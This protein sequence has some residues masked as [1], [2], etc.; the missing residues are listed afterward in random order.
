LFLEQD[1]EVT[2]HLNE[3]YASSAFISL[4][5]TSLSPSSRVLST[6]A[7]SLILALSASSPSAAA[8]A[9]TAERL[10]P[11]YRA[12]LAPLDVALL[13]LFQRIEIASGRSIAPILKGWNPAAA[14]ATATLLDGSRVGALGASQRPFVRRSWARAFASTRTAY[15]EAD[16]ARTYDPRFIVSLVGALVAEDELK[17]AEWTTVLESG[18]V[19]TVVA[20]L[21]SSEKSLRLQARATLG[22]LLRKI[23]VRLLCSL[24]LSSSY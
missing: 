20:S 9:R 22:G 12:T 6:P 17:V 24:D 15:S 18:A 21:A 14:D 7:L 16:D 2:R 4:T 3:I 5:A 19:G 23:K 1:T 11:F 10:V 8:N 13:A